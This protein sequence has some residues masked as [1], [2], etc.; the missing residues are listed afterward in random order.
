VPAHIFFRV[1]D[2]A[3]ACLDGPVSVFLTR[4]DRGDGRILERPNAVKRVTANNRDIRSEDP[5]QL[6]GEIG[7]LIVGGASTHHDPFALK[8]VQLGNLL[9]R[10]AKV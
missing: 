3:P 7:D 1:P 4:D 9:A 2:Q 8:V 10:G 6:L 5:T